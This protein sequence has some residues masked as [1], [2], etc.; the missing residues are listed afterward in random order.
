MSRSTI[1]L[2]QTS[3]SLVLK[4]QPNN[5]KY[6]VENLEALRLIWDQ[7]V[8][9]VPQHL[10]FDLGLAIAVLAAGSADPLE[11]MLDPITLS[12]YLDSFC[13]VFPSRQATLNLNRGEQEGILRLARLRNA[14][15][16]EASWKELIEQANRAGRTQ[17]PG[18]NRL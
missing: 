3:N 14:P 16:F 2:E 17:E 5:S 18:V 9:V 8:Q 12:K 11:P 13:L 1:R 7:I 10:S 4:L 15:D 6:E